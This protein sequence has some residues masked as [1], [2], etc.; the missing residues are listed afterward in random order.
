MARREPRSNAKPGRRPL[1]REN[2]ARAATGFRDM[3]ERIDNTTDRIANNIEAAM[4]GLPN[5]NIVGDAQTSQG[6]RDD[7]DRRT[8]QREVFT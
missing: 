4:F 7:N 5:R 3:D 8:A 6:G 2:R 1:F